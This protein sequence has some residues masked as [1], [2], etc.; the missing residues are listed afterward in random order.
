VPI[1]W[2]CWP[3]YE[4]MRALVESVCRPF[5]IQLL[6]CATVSNTSA[7]RGLVIILEPRHCFTC[8]MQVYGNPCER[9]VA[10]EGVCIPRRLT[11]E[12]LH[13][14]RTYYR[15]EKTCPLQLHLSRGMCHLSRLLRAA[16]ESPCPAC[17]SP[18]FTPRSAYG[19]GPLGTSV[20]AGS[21]RP[22]GTHVS[23]VPNSPPVKPVHNKILNVRLLCTSGRPQKHMVID[24]SNPQNM[25]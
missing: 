8:T 3:S 20:A 21:H 12:L 15:L 10:A 6:S 4:Y 16:R 11:A 24:P 7:S 22:A 18:Q 19:Y 2:P 9:S 14:T 25:A 1:C 17:I 23:A 13:N 5:V